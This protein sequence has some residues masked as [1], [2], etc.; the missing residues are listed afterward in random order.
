VATVPANSWTHVAATCEYIKYKQREFH[1]Y[2][3]GKE[4]EEKNEGVGG[5]ALDTPKVYIG[6]GYT[7][8]LSGSRFHGLIDEV[9]IYNRVLSPSEIFE[10]YQHFMDTEPPEITLTVNPNL[11]WPPNHKMVDIVATVTVSDLCDENPTW[12][13]L[14]IT[15][16]EPEE[17][18]GNKNYPDIMGHE[19]GTADTQ[20]Q[21]RAERLGTGSSRVYTITYQATDA[22]NNSA[23]AE[24]TVTVPHDLSKPLASSFD[25]YNPPDSYQ[26]FQNYPNPFNMQTQIRYQ[27]PQATHVNLRIVNMLGTEVCRLADAYQETGYYSLIWDGKDN[28]GQEVASGVYFIEMKA[29]AFMELKK[30]TVF[31]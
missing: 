14:S 3:D 16:N 31:K 4:I 2:I 23:T 22:S 25:E 10:R 7:C 30:L 12:K 24:A 18:P 13:L 9:V 29:G 6:G 27:I 28:L 8:S 17:G 20:F 26:L 11:L 19:V 15:S 21:L 1:L 5:T